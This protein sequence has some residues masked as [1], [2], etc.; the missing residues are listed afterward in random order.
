MFITLENIIY[1]ITDRDSLRRLIY[2]KPVL[3]NDIIKQMI[4]NPTELLDIIGKDKYDF[5]L[6][7]RIL[8]HEQQV[9]ILNTLIENNALFENY[10]LSSF[11]LSSCF[12]QLSRELNIIILGHIVKHP[13]IFDKI[14]GNSHFFS[15]LLKDCDD[16]YGQIIIDHIVDYPH[17]IRQLCANS[18]LLIHI[19]DRLP[20][21]YATQLFTKI[22]SLPEMVNYYFS[23]PFDFQFALDTLT[24]SLAL[25]LAQHHARRQHVWHNHHIIPRL[26]DIGLDPNIQ[27]NHG[28]NALAHLLNS[29]LLLKTKFELGRKMIAHG[30][31]P[32]TQDKHGKTLL[33]HLCEAL[34][35]EWT[36]YIPTL[37]AH[38]ADPNIPVA[39]ENRNALDVI[40]LNSFLSENHHRIALLLLEHGAKPLVASRYPKNLFIILYK[41]YPT[42]HQEFIA[43]GIPAAQTQQAQA[44][45]HKL[46]PAEVAI[47]I[48]QHSPARQ[49]RTSF[50]NLLLM[51][52]R[53]KSTPENP[54]FFKYLPNEILCDIA[55]QLGIDDRAACMAL[56]HGMQREHIRINE[57]YIKSTP[58]GISVVQTRQSNGEYTLRFSKDNVYALTADYI[59]LKNNLVVS[60]AKKFPMLSW[61]LDKLKMHYVTPED[62]QS[63]QNFRENFAARNFENHCNFFKIETG[64]GKRRALYNQVQSSEL[65][66]DA[67]VKKQLQL[68]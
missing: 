2:S 54:S 41:H 27:D 14:I 7:M 47:A 28:Q 10:V 60:Q 53:D 31:D 26:L 59:Q 52:V 17:L 35:Y 37:I 38:G 11:D 29:Q 46:S 62:K 57:L 34:N 20:E 3:V 6:L 67:E 16:A 42:L 64:T 55:Q 65:F 63:L 58:R 68:K 13:A 21:K 4:A 9:V 22:L 12:T 56:I 49:A 23:A 15:F 8:P 1:D 40:M 51:L 33:Y 61:L 66:D 32:N 30:V 5:L 24:P 25:L 45:Y 50:F 44:I 48:H 39:H 43:Q 18:V 36:D 19:L